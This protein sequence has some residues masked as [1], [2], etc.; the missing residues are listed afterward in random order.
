MHHKRSKM[1]CWLPPKIGGESDN[2]SLGKVFV[3]L[4]GVFT[5]RTIP[6]S[7][8]QSLLRLIM[9]DLDIKHKMH[10]NCRSQNVVNNIHPGLD[11][12]QMVGALK[13]RMQANSNTSPNKFI[14]KLWGNDTMEYRYCRGPYCWYKLKQTIKEDGNSVNFHI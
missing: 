14:Y 11:S 10:W 3:D 5:I 6:S 1:N 9:T 8:T 12:K 4:L 13:I 2:Q 7:K